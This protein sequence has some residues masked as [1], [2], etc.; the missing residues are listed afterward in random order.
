M[1]PPELNRLTQERNEATLKAQELLEENKR[2]S[3]RLGKILDRTYS[4]RENALLLKTVAKS[5]IKNTWHLLQS[6]RS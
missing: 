2:L 5:S 1:I 6:L 4:W 3:S